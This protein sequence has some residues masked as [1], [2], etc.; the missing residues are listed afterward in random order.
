M[1]NKD[2]GNGEGPDG[3]SIPIRKSFDTIPPQTGRLR[4]LFS[5]MQER[6]NSQQAESQEGS[7][8]RR[9]TTR[10]N[11]SASASMH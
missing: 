10:R 6:Q 7:G 5:E 11:D 1:S 2:K 3:K 8:D 4:N 9:D